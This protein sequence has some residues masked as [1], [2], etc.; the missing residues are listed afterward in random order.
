MT[1]VLKD[2]SLSIV[3]TFAG[4]A[5]VAGLTVEE[6]YGRREKRRYSLTARGQSRNAVERLLQQAD[7]ADLELDATLSASLN[8]ASQPIEAF[9]SLCRAVNE[10]PAVAEKHEC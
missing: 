1:L 5:F 10:M 3:R 4:E 6:A 9:R 2:E 8:N 7:E